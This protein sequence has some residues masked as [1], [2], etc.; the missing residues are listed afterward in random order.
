[1]ASPYRT[2]AIRY[3]NRAKKELRLTDWRIRLQWCDDPDWD[4]YATVAPNA[5]RP[6]A[7]ITLSSINIHSEEDFLYYIVHELSHLVVIPLNHLCDD[8]AAGMSEEVKSLFERQ[9]MRLTENVVDHMA[10]VV[11]DNL[12]AHLIKK[13]K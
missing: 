8:Y 4:C 9:V 13:D 12:R 5:D 10:Q 3:I 1:M 7:M 6:E 2:K 11:F